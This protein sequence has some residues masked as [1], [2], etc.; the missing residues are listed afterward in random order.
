VSYAANVD[1]NQG[2]IVRA[3]RKVGAS[4]EFIHREGRGSPTF[5]SATG[6]ATTSSR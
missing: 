4:V 5:S 2:D 6:G 1:A 3:L